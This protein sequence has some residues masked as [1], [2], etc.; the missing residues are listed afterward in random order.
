MEH[1]GKHRQIQREMY[2]PER[3]ILTP[4]SAEA[5]AES[6]C[7]PELNIP[8]VIPSKSWAIAKCPFEGWKNKRATVV[9]TGSCKICD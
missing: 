4:E 1:T 7:L 5:N 6:K 9:A 2:F 8:F 3:K